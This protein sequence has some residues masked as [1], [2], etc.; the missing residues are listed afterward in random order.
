VAGVFL[1]GLETVEFRGGDQLRLH[2]VSKRG[3][4]RRGIIPELVVF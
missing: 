1:P 4:I 2:Q 3:V